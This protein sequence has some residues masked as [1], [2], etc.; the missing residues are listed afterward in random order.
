MPDEIRSKERRRA[1]R[2]ARRLIRFLKEDYWWEIRF[3]DLRDQRVRRRIGFE[4][5][6]V[7]ALLDDTYRICIDPSYGDF[8]G[9][10]IHEC[11]HAVFPDMEE[12]DVLEHERLIRL[13]LTCDQ[14]ADLLLW[15]ARRLA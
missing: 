12:A 3:M 6:I 14:A 4:R 15:A 7:G 13:H 2:L 8:F 10:L 9:V 1:H 5:K 11:L